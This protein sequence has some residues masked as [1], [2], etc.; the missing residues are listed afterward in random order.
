[1]TSAAANNPQS[2]L[3]VTLAGLYTL[4]KVLNEGRHGALF[5]ARHART[6]VRYAVRLVRSD[7]ARAS[8]LSEHLKR[9]AAVVHPHLIAPV[10]VQ[11]L[12]DEQLVIA[13]PFLPGQDLN[14]R[15][16]ARG[17]L[18]SA[19]GQAMMRQLASALHALQ[20]AGTCHGNLSATNVFFCRYD[21]LA[22]DSPLA[23]GKGTHRLVLIDPGLSILDGNRPTSADDQRGLGRMM[24]SFVSDLSPATK[25][26]LERTQEANPDSRYR[27]I[28]DLWRF[29]DEASGSKPGAGGKSQVR[30]VATTVVPT[31]K[32]D[33]KAG[34]K[35]RRMYALG[36]AAALGLLVVAI[37]A[38]L[39]GRKPSP[40][41]LPPPAAETSPS[42]EAKPSSEKAAPETKVE[43][44]GEGAGEAA[45]AD[46]DGRGESKPAKSKK[47][48]SKKGK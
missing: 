1:M 38:M 39:I 33:P 4:D 21:D 22:V 18:S 6:G 23:D 9:V 48:K 28:A 25:Q 41:P 27:T 12:P 14:Q 16:A 8:A 42:P 44:P 40:P 45:A 35:Q 46:S 32:F 47:K 20:L 2:L 11:V 30:A 26:V 29:F 7:S 34:S 24:S 17:K 5:D 3:G 10:E 13:T 19:E 31:L 15:I 43:A 37:A 36:G